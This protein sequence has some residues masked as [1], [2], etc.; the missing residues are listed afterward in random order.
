MSEIRQPVPLYVIEKSTKLFTSIIFGGT[1][2]EGTK[3]YY[4]EDET[5][6][7]LEDFHIDICQ[8]GKFAATFDTGKF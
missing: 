6:D 2:V 7:Q 8:N 5:T 3:I 4:G 1:S